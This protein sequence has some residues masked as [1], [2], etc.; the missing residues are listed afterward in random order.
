MFLRREDVV[1]DSKA[2]AVAFH[3]LPNLLL[4]QV[5]TV[6]VDERAQEVLEAVVDFRSRGQHG[7]PLLHRVPFHVFQ[8]LDRFYH[9]KTSGTCAALLL[10]VFNLIASTSP[11]LRPFLP[12]LVLQDVC[13]ATAVRRPHQIH[14]HKNN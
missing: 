8:I 10:D 6:V 4:E 11:P 2:L 9:L 3:H 5:R 1:V 12:Q 7:H 13:V 14:L